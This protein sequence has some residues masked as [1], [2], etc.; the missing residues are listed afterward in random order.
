[1]TPQVS[2]LLV[3]ILYWF[4]AYTADQQLQAAVITERVESEAVCFNIYTLHSAATCD[5][6]AEQLKQTPLKL[7]YYESVYHQNDFEA[8]V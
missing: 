7:L 2:S 6:G 3:H 8:A 5:Q 1:M 4:P